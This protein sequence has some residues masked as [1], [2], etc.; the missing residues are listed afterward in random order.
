MRRPINLPPTAMTPSMRSRRPLKNPGVTD[1]SAAD[2]NSKLVAAMPEITVDG[3]TGTMTWT[4]EGETVKREG[5]DHPRRRR[6][7]LHQIDTAPIH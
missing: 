3:V 1:P 6:C 7:A 4:A 2:F 5:H